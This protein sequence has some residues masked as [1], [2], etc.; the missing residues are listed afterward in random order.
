MVR[1]PG[2]TWLPHDNASYD[3]SFNSYNYSYTGL[4]PG[5][6]AATPMMR[7]LNYAAALPTQ[8]QRRIHQLQ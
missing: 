5:S 2:N 4:N 6:M 3:Y 7:E 8:L 1:S